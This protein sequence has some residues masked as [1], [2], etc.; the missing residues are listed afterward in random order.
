MIEKIS[1]EYGQTVKKFR[2]S[3][4]IVLTDFDQ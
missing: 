2:I 4:L 3:F 1:Y